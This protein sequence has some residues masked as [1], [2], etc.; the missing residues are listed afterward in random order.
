MTDPIPRFRCVL[1]EQWKDVEHYAYAEMHADSNGPYVLAAD[2]EAH[3]AAAVAASIRTTRGNIGTAYRL[4]QRD[5]RAR[6]RAGVEALIVMVLSDTERAALRAVLAVI[7]ATPQDEPD[8]EIRRKRKCGCGHIWGDHDGDDVCSRCDCVSITPPAAPQ[9][10]PTV[11]R[12]YWF[13][14]TH[15]NCPQRGQKD[16][17]GCAICQQD[18]KGDTDGRPYRPT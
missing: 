11:K 8:W 17:V 16:Y 3:E 1:V 9:D 6:I 12:D 15:E 13:T 10:E 5:E 18:E 7:D 2:A 4:G 14:H